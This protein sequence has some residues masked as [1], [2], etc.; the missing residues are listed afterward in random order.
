MRFSLIMQL[1]IAAVNFGPRLHPSFVRLFEIK[2]IFMVNRSV[3][4]YLICTCLEYT[5]SLSI[6]KIVA[7]ESTTF[8]G[9]CDRDGQLIYMYLNAGCNVH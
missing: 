9:A 7:L 5:C 3:N 2:K 6:Q 1:I 4:F 8:F